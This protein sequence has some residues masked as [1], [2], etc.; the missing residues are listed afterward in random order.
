MVVVSDRFGFVDG[1]RNLGLQAWQLSPFSPTSKW[2]IQ[3]DIGQ[4][5]IRSGTIHIAWSE[6]PVRKVGELLELMWMVREL[7]FLIVELPEG[8][9]TLLKSAGFY[10][11]PFE[12][13]G[14]EIWRRSP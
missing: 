4:S 14:Y 6:L 11:L 12:W 1:L 8:G 13:H 7:G 3:G 9:R 5:P 10:T 2:A